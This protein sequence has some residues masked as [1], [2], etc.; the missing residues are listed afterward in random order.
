M[1]T[2]Q[3]ALLVVALATSIASATEFSARYCDK[4]L[5][6]RPIKLVPGRKYARDRPIDIQHLKLDVTPDFTKRTIHATAALTFKPIARPLPK[7]ELDAIDLR[8]E[9]IDCKGASIADRDVA[10]EKLTLTF[11]QPVPADAEVTVSITYHAQPEQGL[12]FRTPETGCKPGDTQMWSQGEAELHRFWFPS[13]DYPNERFTSEVTCHAPEGMEVISNGK[14]LSKEKGA[15][16]LM[17]WHWLQD[18]PHVNYLVALA[19]GYFHKE[20]DKAGALPLAVFVPP[21][22]AA[23]AK[24]ALLDTKKIIEFY[25]RETGTPF[26][27]DK[28]HQVYCLDFLAGGMENTSCT[29]LAA[30]LLYSKETE[31]LRSLHDLD[32]HETAHQWFGDLVTCRDWSHLW[33]NEGFA[34]YYTVLYEE[35]KLGRDAMLYSLWREADQVFKAN[36]QRPTV[37]RDYEDPMQ[38]F[39][40]RVYP[41]GAWIL[42]MLRSQLGADLY[43][44]GI[45]LYLARHRNQV[46]GTDDLHDVMSEVSGLSLDAFFDQWLYH[47]AFPELSIDYSWDA[48]AKHAKLTV[49]QTQKL[50]DKVMLFRLPLPVR[51][52]IAGESKPL[53][54]TANVTQTTEDFYF[55][56]PRQPDLVRIDPDYTILAK[57]DFS[58]PPDMLKRQLQSDVIGRMLAVQKLGGRKDAETVKQLV[59]VLNGDAFHGVRTEAARILKKI[60]TP[61]SRAALISGIKQDDARVRKEV[62]E[63]L[64]AFHEPDAWSALA[65]LADTEKNPEIRAGI[66]RTWGARPGDAEITPRLK[67]ELASKSYGNI[68]A[69]AA[70]DAL[71]A[72]NDT[73]AA[74]A[75][76]GRLRASPL[77]FHSRDFAA[78][79]DSLAFLAREQ[80]DREPVRQFIAGYLTSPREELRKGSAKALG[81][82]RDPKSIALLRPLTEVEKPFNDPVREAAEK[83]IQDLQALLAGPQDL[84]SVWS[85]MQALKKKTEDLQKELE[86]VKKKAASQRVESKAKPA[87]P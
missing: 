83:S 45:Q 67:T 47:G 33:L 66:V 40:S 6:P 36:D 16:G 5:L 19:A 64:A 3:L 1:N 70:I 15:S 49:K 85:E 38:Q 18:K 31:Q 61:E 79:L 34:S 32:A 72:Q 75:V 28:Y 11:V 56:L 9:N 17:S 62:V 35:E 58:P 54:F 13:Y 78:A 24:N 86:T 65:K 37:W 30:G 73:E 77:E 46:V 20:E 27:W 4:N 39:D 60:A 82:L 43:R 59:G 10:A 21:S 51:F 8:I 44:K 48:G 80:K 12:Y 42:H 69:L 29:F 55:S 81:T 2:R 84:K 71:R 68:V 76:L 52:T 41:R 23:Q 25:N 63:A 57:T 14:L 50:S 22:E 7:L 26:A 53:D 87:K 74:P